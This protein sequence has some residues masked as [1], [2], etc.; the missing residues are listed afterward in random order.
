MNT[1]TAGEARTMVLRAA[2][3]KDSECKRQQAQAA[4]KTLEAAGSPVTFTAV[5]KA[6]GVSRWLVYADGVR[7]Q[8]DAAR[9][10]QGEGGT[11]PRSEEQ[12]ATQAGLQTDLM[13]AREEIRRLRVERESLTQRLRLQLG[14][15]IEGPDKAQ[16]IARVADLEIVNRQ[17]A[18][19]RSAS[20][21]E[22]DAAKH[23]IT[24]L[25]DDLSASRESLRRIIREQNLGR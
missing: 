3:A 1:A 9:R 12:R 16:L 23:R 5:A 15:E 10:R 4:I 25:E 13:V 11:R 17:L 21:L 22:T 20:I 18:A 24:E 2:R 19:E 6:A 14:A 7:E 8:V